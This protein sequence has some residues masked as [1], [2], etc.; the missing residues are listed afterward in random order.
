MMQ[1]VEM[2]VEALKPY[3]NNPRKIGDDAIEA[4]AASLKAFGFQQPI[5]IDRN[6]VI[7]AGHTR[8]M[9]AQ[10]LGLDTVPC[11]YADELNDDEARAYR[12]ADNKTGELAA[13]DF[14]KLELE[15]QDLDVVELEIMGFDGAMFPR[16]RSEERER[17]HSQESKDFLN[18]I[19]DSGFEEDSDEYKDF[20]EKFQPKHT[21]DDCYTPPKVYDAVAD[22]TAQEYNLNRADFVRPFKPGGDYAKENY[23]GKI[24][25]DNPPFSILSD[26]VKFYCENGIKFLL[27]CPTLTG[28]V[29]YADLCTAFPTG[30]DVTY[31]NGAVISTSF[32][33]NLDPHEIRARTVPSLYAAVKKANDE[34]RKEQT[35]EL[36]KYSYPLEL[37]TSAQMYPFARYGV[38]FKI[39]RSESVRVQALDA[40]KAEKKA[41]FGC[42]W[43]ISKELKAEREKAERE[44]AEREKAEREKAEREKAF[45]YKL[46]DRELEIVEGLSRK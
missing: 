19:L 45:R 32:V 33:T 43:L 24:V 21:T 2:P 35:K 18:E 8:L 10:R 31:E 17:D 42:G 26:I 1:I 37:I 5:V 12:L 15:V 9:A 29:R 40:Q 11:K 14:E 6:N 46:S 30:V 4:V 44:K 34:V 16:V 38:E 28:I 3:E 20:V 23:S 22:W 36:P 27:F 39:P 7:I 41:V 25:V 13:W